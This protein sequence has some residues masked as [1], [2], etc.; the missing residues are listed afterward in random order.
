MFITHFI[1][2]FSLFVAASPS[3]QMKNFCIKPF[4]RLTIDFFCGFCPFRL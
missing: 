2:V 3:I 1:A 4:Y